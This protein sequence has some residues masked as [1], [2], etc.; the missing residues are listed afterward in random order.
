MLELS[1]DMKIACQVYASCRVTNISSR[2][3]GT[4]VLGYYCEPSQGTQTGGNAEFCSSRADASDDELG[5][6]MAAD[7]CER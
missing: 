7:G 2:Q 1:T 5:C 4:L 6:I 3:V